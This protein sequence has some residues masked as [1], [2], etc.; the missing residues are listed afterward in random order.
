MCFGG[1]DPLN[2]T[3][4]VADIIVELG[5][6]DVCVVLGGA[7]AHDKSAFLADEVVEVHRDLDPREFIE[8]M[9]GCSFAV[10]P[11]STVLLE[12][13][14]VGMP[15]ITG[16]YAD[17]QRYSLQFFEN[18]GAIEN[19]GNLREDVNVKLSEAVE[20]VIRAGRA[21]Y[22][23]AQRELPL[24]GDKIQEVLSSL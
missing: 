4:V 22:L 24:S 12:C 16:W 13:F 3:K 18:L 15:V 19:C 23:S 8:V 1:S 21:K 2:L 11:A 14:C 20:H 5:V 17:N 10:V 6:A 7:S 9:R